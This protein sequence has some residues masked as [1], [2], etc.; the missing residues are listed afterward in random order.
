MPRSLQKH[1]IHDNENNLYNNIWSR[2]DPPRTLDEHDKRWHKGEEFC[3]QNTQVW[4]DVHGT[5]KNSND[6]NN[7][8]EL[9][10]QTA[11]DCNKIK[12]GTADW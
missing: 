4:N 1:T 3:T 5:V 12:T 2:P 6:C 10:I 7:E 11:N 9:S 8:I